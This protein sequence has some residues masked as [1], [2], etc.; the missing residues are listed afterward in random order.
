MNCSKLLMIC[1]LVPF[2]AKAVVVTLGP[3]TQAVTFT[4][5]GTNAS[6]AGTSQVAWGACSFDG[7]NTTCTVS[8]P[9]TGLGNGGTYSFVV[10]YP[11]NGQTPL[12]AVASPPGSD[13]VIFTLSAGSIEFTLTPTGGAAVRFYDLNSTML[14]FSPATDSCTGVSTCSVGAV[15]MSVG[16]T[17]TGPVNGS[18][19]TTPI[20]NVSGVVTATDYGGFSA[21]APATFVEIYGLNLATTF[22]MVW[23]SSFQAGKAPTSLGGTTV[24]VAG[25]SAF[26]ELAGP[27]QVNVLVPDGVPTARSQWLSRRLVETVSRQWLQ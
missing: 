3:S 18:F 24:A 19:D 13:L 27:H 1:V 14:F 6:G 22:H 21:I 12:V 25:K 8:G 20:I 11:G 9:Y 26:V 15:G 4:G 17:I 16:G 2:T 5:I 23:G 10:T 7:T